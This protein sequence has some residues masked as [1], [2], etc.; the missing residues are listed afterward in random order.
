VRNKLSDENISDAGWTYRVFKSECIAH[1]KFFN[2]ALRFFP[3]LVKME[4]FRVVEGP[5][6]TNPRFSGTSLYCVWNRLFKSFCD[7]LAVRCMKSRIQY[8]ITETVNCL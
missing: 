7:L 8:E 5:V 4:G 6:S 3:T 2:G 1:V